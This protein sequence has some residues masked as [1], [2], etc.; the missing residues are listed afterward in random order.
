MAASVGVDDFRSPGRL[1]PNVITQVILGWLVGNGT[2][3][4]AKL[5]AFRLGAWLEFPS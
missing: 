2:I 4:A 3:V 5:R 1:S